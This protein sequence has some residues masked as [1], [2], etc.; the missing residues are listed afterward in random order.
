ML[1]YLKKYQELNYK[2]KMKTI[3]NRNESYQLVDKP[4]RKEQVLNA[5]RELGNATNSELSKRLKLPINS[6][7][8][9]C[10]EL[11][12]DGRVIETG[13]KFDKETNRTVT[14]FGIYQD[15]LF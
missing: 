10:K 3:T 5:L 1:K 12:E 11:R 15:T 8:G 6:I 2:S 4:T 9:R 14:V 13:S 7:T